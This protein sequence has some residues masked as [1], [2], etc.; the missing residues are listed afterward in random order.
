MRSFSRCPPWVGIACALLSSPIWADTHDTLSHLV[1]HVRNW[2]ASEPPQITWNEVSPGLGGQYQLEPHWAWQAGVY[3]NSLSRSA[4]YCLWDW[5][6]LQAGRW[7][8]GLSVG[9]V[10]GG[11]HQRVK[12]VAGLHGQWQHACWGVASRAF[13]KP[14]AGKFPELHRS[15]VTALELAGRLP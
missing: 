13:P 4:A 8:A 6:T 9:T 15:A 3:R 1:V 14:P 2:N 12:A 10:V 7:A 5:T 11:Y